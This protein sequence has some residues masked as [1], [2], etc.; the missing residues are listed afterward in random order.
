MSNR[1]FTKKKLLSVSLAMVIAGSAAVATAGPHFKDHAMKHKIE[2]MLKRLDLSEEQE[3]QID[4]IL[5][6]MKEA[7]KERRGFPQ[8]KAMMALDP[9]AEDYLQ[10]AE[11]NATAASEQ[12]K[13][14][15]LQMATVRKEIHEVL[16]DEQ[17]A[18]L[19]AM[20]EKKLSRM[21]ERCEDDD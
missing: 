14:R 7:R 20:V 18:E 4:E 5:A 1:L 6:P 8:M 12:V 13:A 16:N 2:R 10:Q 3:S 21:E 17:K 9:E 15:I 11:T 19:K